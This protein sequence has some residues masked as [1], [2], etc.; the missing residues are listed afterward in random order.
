MRLL[1]AALSLFAA[2]AGAS[3]QNL[4]GITLNPSPTN[5]LIAR[6]SHA[7]CSTLTTCQTSLPASGLWYWPGGTAWDPTSNSVWA[8]T[9]GLLTRQ[10]A[11]TCAVNFGPVACPVS[12]GANATGLD[13]H[14]S[15]NELWAIDSNGWIT[16]SQN[17]T[18][19]AFVNAHNTG[20]AIS[21]FVAT[22]AITIDELRGL[23]F[24]ST[25]D[26]QFGQ[27]WIYV[28]P[29]S[30]PGAWYQVTPVQ[31]CF[32]NPTMITGMACDAANSA[33]YWT[34]GRGT[35]RWTYTVSGPAV[36]FTPGTCC[37]QTAP[38]QDPLTDLSMQWAPAVSSGTP[39]ANGGCAPC[40][41]SH[42]LRN[43]PLLG[44]NLQLGLDLAQVGMP[45]WCIVG[46][47][48]CAPSSI[49]PPLCGPVLV[50]LG[51]ASVTLPMQFPT[52]GTGCT[53]STTWFLWLP[54]N[55]SLV[56]L[57][58]SSQCIGLCPPTGTAMSNC[59]SFVLQ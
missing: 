45:T 24:Y 21:G 1:P 23:V 18:G 51:A 26:F 4:L 14:D 55:P 50:A 34:N 32:T 20:L 30:N 11:T 58:M 6:V 48:S 44:T 22:S 5:P 10:S 7:T 35:F 46:I 47:G 52:G 31:D 40:P 43:A 57:P 56:G 2:V 38:F 19:L 54:P 13:L 36:T 42:L 9:G 33:L 15:W 49:V 12:L 28:A 41:M 17:N 59:L 25:C 37:I 3:A 53:G 27:G 29:M 16:R 8:T 39:C